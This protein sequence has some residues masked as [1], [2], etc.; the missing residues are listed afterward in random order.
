MS[1]TKAQSVVLACCMLHNYTRRESI[2]TYT[3]PGFADAVDADGNI[4]DGTWRLDAVQSQ[5][6]TASRQHTTSANAVR[7]TLVDYL[8]SPAGRLEWQMLHVNRTN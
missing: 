1:A 6:T 5:P 4:I 8:S 3:P 2:R 7:E